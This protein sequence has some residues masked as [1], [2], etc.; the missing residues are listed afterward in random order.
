MR[1]VKLIK[2][3]IIYYKCYNLHVKIFIIHTLIKK[4]LA[5]LLTLCYVDQ[6]L[7]EKLRKNSTYRDAKTWR[8]RG[9]LKH[10]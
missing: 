3:L 6:Y 1:S 10:T 9:V 8:A 4:Y 7:S 5:L 2:H